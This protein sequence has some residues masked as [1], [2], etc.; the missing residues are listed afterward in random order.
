MFNGH[1]GA[2]VFDEV[3]AANTMGNSFRPSYLQVGPLLDDLLAAAN[4]RRR[5]AK[6]ESVRRPCRWGFTATLAPHDAST[7]RRLC[8]FDSPVIHNQPPRRWNVSINRC[9][10]KKHSDAMRRVLDAADPAEDDDFDDV[11]TGS[12]KRLVYCLTRKSCDAVASKMTERKVAFA[13]VHGKVPLWKKQ[14]ALRSLRSGDCQTV[15]CTDSFGLGVNVN[16][17]AAVDELLPPLSLEDLHQKLGRAARS[18]ECYGEYNLHVYPTMLTAAVGLLRKSPRGLASFIRVLELAVDLKHCLH[19]YLDEYL[20]DD[21]CRISARPRDFCCANCRCVLSGEPYYVDVDVTSNVQALC[22]CVM[23]YI[24]ETGLP[25]TASFLYE[26]KKVAP[27]SPRHWTV[28][29]RVWLVLCLLAQREHRLLRILSPGIAT[30]ERDLRGVR[31]ETDSNVFADLEHVVL[32]FPRAW[33]PRPPT[34][35]AD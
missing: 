22:G 17:I 12:Q 15:V 30:P 10:S 13:K 28:Q 29:S 3:H 27:W 5:R 31:V 26:E 1:V 35:L 34:D 16:D 2:V 33:A 8:G 19:S 24:T 4:G 23:G 9:L 21:R 14:E 7:I 25:P 32:R 11:D 20:A 18:P 6:R